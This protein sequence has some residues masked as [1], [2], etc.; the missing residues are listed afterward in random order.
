MKKFNNK[1]RFIIKTKILNAF[2]LAEIIIVVGIIGIIA[3]S[4]IPTLVSDFQKQTYAVQLKKTYS[5]IN[6]AFAQY[7]ADKGCIDDLQCT[8][9]FSDTIS[10]NIL[11]W[12]EFVNN[13]FSVAKN[14][15]IS[16]DQNCF[17]SVYK[18]LSGSSTVNGPNLISAVYKILLK[19]GTSIGFMRGSDCAGLANISPS[20]QLYGI[21]GNLSID[22]NGLKNPNKAGRDYFSTN[23]FAITRHHGV[24]TYYGNENYANATGMSLYYWKTAT[25]SG[26]KCTTDADATGSACAARIIEEGWQMKY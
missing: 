5:M 3:E 8:G 14:C 9:L 21:C 23:S 25:S 1:N 11:L 16:T 12:D 4:T 15:G 2:T 19:D 24:V 17:T 20:N 18:V 22:I 7:A 10:N 13:Y 6:Q 26:Y